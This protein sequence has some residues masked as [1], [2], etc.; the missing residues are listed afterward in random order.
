LYSPQ[1]SVK[2]NGYT[3]IRERH[4]IH[5]YSQPSLIVFWNLLDEMSSP[6]I[7]VFNPIWGIF[8]SLYPSPQNV[9]LAQH[10]SEMIRFIHG[11]ILPMVPSG[12]IHHF[13][14]FQR[15]PSRSA[16]QRRTERGVVG[17]FCYLNK[18][19]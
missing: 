10:V 9:A 1:S 19:E 11:A 17:R 6:V 2:K 16:R 4:N 18:S 13:S 15:S 12:V 3:P 14:I 8:C 7:M 5:N